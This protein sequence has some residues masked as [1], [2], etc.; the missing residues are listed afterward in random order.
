MPPPKTKRAVAH[1]YYMWPKQSGVPADVWAYVDVL[2]MQGTA[3]Q[4]AHLAE[5]ITGPGGWNQACGV[6]FRFSQR[7]DAPV[8]VTFEI[9]ASWSQLGNYGVH[10]PFKK[11][12]M[13]LGWLLEGR[14]SEI[15]WRRVALHEFGH[16]LALEHEQHHPGVQIP[17]DREAVYQYF[18]DKDH[19]SRDRVDAQIFTPLAVEVAQTTAYDPDSIMHYAIP[20]Y[21]LTDPSW[22]VGSNW[23]LSAGD[24]AAVQAW[25][26]PPPEQPLTMPP[27]PH[28]GETWDKTYFPVIHRK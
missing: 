5:I 6:Q 15:E 10:G 23:Q 2:V 25:Y 4:A 24:V 1:K 8:R 28:P 19:W 12:T 3:E 26:G 9:G 13:Q 11:P 7:A 21:L 16:A 22:A 14:T 20:D 17:W 18:W 27:N